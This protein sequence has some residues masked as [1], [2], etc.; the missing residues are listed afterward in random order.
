MGQ[1]GN[2][3]QELAHVCSPNAQGE[4]YNDNKRTCME[5]QWWKQK[6]RK[7]AYLMRG[8]FMDVFSE[9]ALQKAHNVLVNSN[10]FA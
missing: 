6:E 10:M 1:L 9:R 7:S 8:Y 3:K 5:A 4:D 2:S